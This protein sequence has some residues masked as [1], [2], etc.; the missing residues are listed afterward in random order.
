MN[1][2]L[3]EA[4]SDL[5]CFH[6]ADDMVAPEFFEQTVG[7]LEKYPE[8][9]LCCSFFSEFR[10]STGEVNYGRRNWSIEPRY[11]SPPE[12]ARLPIAG[13]FPATVRFIRVRQ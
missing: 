13:G 5:I 6:S 1:R 10:P 9:G 11:L 4:K 8:A 3:N 2:G 12:L 7:M